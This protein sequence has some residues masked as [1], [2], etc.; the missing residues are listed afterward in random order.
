[1]CTST[2]QTLSRVFRFSR[3]S[4]CLKYKADLN[5]NI[6]IAIILLQTAFLGFWFHIT[7]WLDM[8]IIKI[9]NVS[10]YNV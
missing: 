3:F 6:L 7:Q 1:M 5:H 9:L 4:F 10:R 2:Q 8:F